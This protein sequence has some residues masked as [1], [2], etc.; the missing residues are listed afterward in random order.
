[1]SNRRDQADSPRRGSTKRHHGLTVS[2]SVMIG[3]K[4]CGG[5]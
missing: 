3:L 2:L 4:P 1:V 5:R